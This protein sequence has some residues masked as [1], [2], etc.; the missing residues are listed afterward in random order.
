MLFGSGS[1]VSGGDEGLSVPG[2]PA[3]FKSSDS[4]FGG[5]AEAF[6]EFEFDCPGLSRFCPEGVPAVSRP[7]PGS[8]PGMS[9][10]SEVEGGV[11]TGLT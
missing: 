10:G 11:E 7:C 4:V 8:V 5:L 9:R 3:E 6:G 1:G 2:V